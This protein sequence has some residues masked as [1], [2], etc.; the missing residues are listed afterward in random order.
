MLALPLP[1]TVTLR[2]TTTPRLEQKGSGG[3]ENVTP[4]RHRQRR[5]GV[6]CYSCSDTKM[7]L[8]TRR[9]PVR[10]MLVAML[11]FCTGTQG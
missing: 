3:P 5:Q 8:G 7:E 10:S 9:L 4:R 1:E 6:C 11:C 2:D